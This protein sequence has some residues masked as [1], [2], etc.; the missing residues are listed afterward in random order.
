MN[1]PLGRFAAQEIRSLGRRVASHYYTAPVAPSLRMTERECDLGRND[2]QRSVRHDKFT[3]E[4]YHVPRMKLIDGKALA[5]AIRAEV[6]DDVKKLPSPPGLG[7]LLVG[8]DPASRV[9]VGLKE[10]TATEAGIRTDIRRLP[11]SATDDELVGI[12]RQ[13]N[14]DGSVNAIL[15]QLPL[16]SGHDTDKV[17]S[18]VHPMKDVD[19]FHPANVE[20]L[21]EGTG[22]IIPPVHEGIMRLIASTGLDPRGK[23]ATII[24]NSDTF[25]DPLHH[26]LRRAGFVTA[27][28]QP[29]D[30]DAETLLQ[31]DV[32]V[33]AI[34]RPGFLGS[35]LVKNGAVVIDVG[36]TK[37]ERGCVRGDAD[38]EDFRNKDVWITPVPGGVGPMTVALLLKNVVRLVELQRPSRSLSRAEPR[39]SGCQRLATRS[40][41]RE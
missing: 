16:P 13:W 1:H 32:A 40:S 19:G 8:D 3:D 4:P 20:A 33:V 15:V 28:M 18:A 2:A 17:V 7:V 27:M 29:D 25:A 9:Y 24:A 35:D 23:S 5:A 6:A 10:K 11:A 37:D 26:L 41:S 12:I 30:L 39:G 31:S 14:E 34:G 22:L 36:T 21:F 38:M